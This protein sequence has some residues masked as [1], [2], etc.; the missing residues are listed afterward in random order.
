MNISLKQKI[1]NREVTIGSWITIGDP[2][3]AEIMVKAGFDWLTVDMEHSAITLSEAQRL[4]QV[5]ELGGKTP[6][7]RVDHNDANIIKR[8][9]DAGAHGI[10]VPMVNTKE[11]ALAAVSAVQYPPKGK[12]GVGLGRAQGYGVAFEKYK[13]WVDTESIVIVQVEHIQA[14]QNLEAILSVEGIDGFLVGPYDLSASLGV[15]G[16]FEHPEMI[17]ALNKIKVVS[18]K[19]NAV[20][21]IH[22]IP[23]K[24]ELVLTKIKEGFQFIAFSLDSLFLAQMCSVG[25]ENIRAACEFK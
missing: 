15:P 12:R 23:P 8:V 3:I 2:C 7:V 1:K 24:P 21:G 5:I 13:K 18:K 4:I 17:K 10:I 25:L 16:E 22:V 20:S 14:V 11:D 6:F 9:M 19:L